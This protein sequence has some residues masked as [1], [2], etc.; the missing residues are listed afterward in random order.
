MATFKDVFWITAKVLLALIL[1]AG[2]VISLPLIIGTLGML[3]N[4]SSKAASPTVPHYSDLL[5]AQADAV[6]N[7]MPRSTWDRG[8]RRAAKS[9]C[10]T[11]GMNKEEVEHAV[12]EPTTKEDFSPGIGSTWT[13]EIDRPKCLKYDGENCVQKEYPKTMIFF[14]PAGNVKSSPGCKTVDDQWIYSSSKAL[15]SR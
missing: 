2:I 7:S 14:T 3:A 4:H 12:G 8:M 1:I 15:F 6:R 13:Y 5:D 9:F 11:E 10:F